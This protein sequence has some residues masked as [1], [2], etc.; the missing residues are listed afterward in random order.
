MST[1]SIAEKIET[2]HK[3][4]K[5]LL[6]AGIVSICMVFGGLTSAYVVRSNDP[7]WLHFGIP[8][9]F[10]VSAGIIFMSSVTLFLATRAAKKDNYRL[11]QIVSNPA[12][13]NSIYAVPIHGM[14][15]ISGTR[16]IPYRKKQ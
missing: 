7:G 11:V 6:Y 15:I 10:Y 9:L 13:W 4:A 12:S 8:F 3:T 16:H 14:A 5:P 2:Q 1:I